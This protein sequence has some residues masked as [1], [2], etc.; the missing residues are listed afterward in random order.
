MYKQRAVPQIQDSRYDYKFNYGQQVRVIETA[1]IGY[2][3]QYHYYPDFEVIYL[4]QFLVKKYPKWMFWKDDEL[5]YK[6][7][8]AHQLEINSLV[9][10]LTVNGT[11]T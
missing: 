9:G 5:R 11:I 6:G 8:Q 10:T 3:D 2:V 4:I 7:Y 1:E